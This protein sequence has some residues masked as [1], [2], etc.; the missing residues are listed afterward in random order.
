MEAKPEEPQ[1]EAKPEEPKMEAKPEEPKVEE[2]KAEAPKVEEPPKTEESKPQEVTP[3][4]PQVT[5]D[6]AATGLETK[7]K[8]KS[9]KKQKEP[10]PPVEYHNIMSGYV[11][12]KGVC[13]CGV[14]D[15]VLWCVCPHLLGHL[16]DSS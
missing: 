15:V 5:E 10:K 11:E 9:V 4:E 12:K 7:Q 2:P 6:A 1:T 3:A 14:V 16:S 8:R 13:I